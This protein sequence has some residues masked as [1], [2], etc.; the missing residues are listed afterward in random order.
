MTFYFSAD[1]HFGCFYFLTSMNNAAINIYVQVVG[2]L[3]FIW[4]YVFIS[5]EYLLRS[6]TAG[7]CGNFMFSPLKN[8]QVVFRSGCIT[9]Y[10]QYVMHEDSSFPTS[11]LILVIT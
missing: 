5:L 7:S 11:L 2:L 6:G 9:L 3:F 8:C 4:T 10:S 1:E